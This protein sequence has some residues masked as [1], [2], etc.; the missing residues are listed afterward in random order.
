VRHPGDAYD[1]V[2]TNCSDLNIVYTH[3]LFDPWSASVLLGGQFTTN[4]E[5]DVVIL[6]F[7]L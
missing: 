7:I 2:I 3:S 4:A 1:N 6:S 5:R